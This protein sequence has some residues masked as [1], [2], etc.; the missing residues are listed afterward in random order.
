MIIGPDGAGTVE[1]H[2]EESEIV[3]V[4]QAHQLITNN[5]SESV[6]R[7]QIKLTGNVLKNYF[8]ETNVKITLLKNDLRC[9]FF[10]ESL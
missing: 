9:V 1:V 8:N 3:S 5:V 10:K 6:L 2:L 7:K 4:Q